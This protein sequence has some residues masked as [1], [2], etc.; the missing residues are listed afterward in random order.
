MP[1]RNSGDSP[2]LRLGTLVNRAGRTLN[3][4][5]SPTDNRP[6]AHPGVVIVRHEP[7]MP[8]E[9]DDSSQ[10]APVVIGAANGGSGNVVDSK[11]TGTLHEISY[12]DGLSQPIVPTARPHVTQRAV[13]GRA[14]IR[15][16]QAL[17]WSAVLVMLLGPVSSTRAKVVP[18]SV[19]PGVGQGGV[20]EAVDVNQPPWR[21]VVLV[22]TEVGLH[23]TGALVGPRLVLTAAHCLF[24]RGTGRLVRPS[25]IHILVGYSYG[26]YEGHAR[27]VAVEIGSGF[28]LGLDG[29]R[30]PSSP[31]DA[32]WAVLTMDAPLGTPDRLLPLSREFPAPGTPVVLG[33]YEQDRAQVIVADVACHVIGAVQAGNSVMLRHSCAGTRGASGAPLLARASNRSWAVVG[34]A[35]VSWVGASG[36]DAVP[37]STITGS[38][39][40]H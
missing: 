36:G 5:R 23:C 14:A 25:S 10:L 21:G 33:G 39:S 40:L 19:L 22:Q 17:T 3:R 8:A 13:G 27:A 6:H 38:V 11:H 30:L 28:A 34:I 4:V 29:Q 9:F 31:P 7:K 15:F 20:R 37:I 35:S 12:E 26:N 24:G 16:V 2:G 18:R 32:D 1:G